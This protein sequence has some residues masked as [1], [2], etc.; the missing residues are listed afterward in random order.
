MRWPMISRSATDIITFATSFPV[1]V[2]ATPR[3][4]VTTDQPRFCDRASNPERSCTERERQSSFATTMSAKS[5][6]F[7]CNRA[8]AD[9]N[10]GRS[11]RLA[12]TPASSCP[13]RRS[14]GCRRS[15]GLSRADCPGPDRSR[16]VPR[17][18]RAGSRSSSLASYHPLL[19]PGRYGTR[20]DK[21]I[22][23]GL[24]VLAA[25]L[26]TIGLGRTLLQAQIEAR[27][28]DKRIAAEAKAA[29]EGREPEPADEEPHDPNMGWVNDFSF[30]LHSDSKSE[31]WINLLLIGVGLGFGA[32]ASIWS[33]FLG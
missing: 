25:L 33:M 23:A 3:S 13:P 16:P 29:V 19:C 30:A 28:N 14:R 24:Y 17:C 22:V 10:A 4:I 27:R 15:A 7:G 12:D 1:G 21:C 2:L 18:L 5:R 11:I 6:R 20:M 9:C 8:N 32:W 26:P 31:A